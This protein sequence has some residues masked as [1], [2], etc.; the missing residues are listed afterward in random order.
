[1]SGRQGAGGFGVTCN[2]IKEDAVTKMESS[3]LR[4]YRGR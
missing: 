2:A 3:N 1:M 4:T